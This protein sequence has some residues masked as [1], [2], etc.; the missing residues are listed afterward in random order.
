MSAM[1]VEQLALWD[2][3]E[4]GLEPLRVKGNPI[5]LM[6]LDFY[7]KIIV[8]FSGGKDSLASVLKLLD[9]GVPKSKIELWHEDVDGGRD[10]ERFMDWPCTRSYCRAVAE[11]LGITIRFQYREGGILREMM[12]ED[13]K[14]GD[15]YYEEPDGSIYCLP[16]KG[17]KES[18]RL[19]WPAMSADLRV[20]WCSAYAKTDVFRKTLNNHP[21]FQGSN[22]DPYRVLVVT[23]ERR[24]E[25]SN[26]AKYHEAE[27]HACNSKTRIVHAWRGV[28]D[29]SEQEVWERIRK[30][31][32]MPAPP[33]FI[34]YSRLS[35]M[36]CIFLGPD[37][38]RIL[39]E[40]APDRFER[41]AQKEEELNHTI[42]QKRD[43]RAKACAG[44]L[45]RMPDDPRL[46]RW[47][48]MALSE[49]FSVD[50]VVMEEWEFPAGAFGSG[51]GPT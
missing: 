6:P 16:T 21:D 33:Y 5:E 44:T 13:A 15:V 29:E 27:L 18:T 35:C 47:I 11:H 22:N 24:E 49:N 36:T 32:I 1:T 23:G 28:I 45:R 46:S 38:W 40:I 17:G 12:R 37:H 19:K 39:K 20:R 34:G 25:S 10:D 26:R 9:L 43:V 8:S 2:D 7:R 31:K 50:D 14:T 30:Y 42:D 48:E 41:I 4:V 51:G 3:E